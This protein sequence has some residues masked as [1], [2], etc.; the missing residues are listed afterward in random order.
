MSKHYDRDEAAE[1]LHSLCRSYGAFEVLVM[2]KN[3]VEVSASVDFHDNPNAVIHKDLITLEMAVA[4][5]MNNHVLRGGTAF[6]AADYSA[7]EQRV[8]VKPIKK[9]KADWKPVRYRG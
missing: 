9:R 3:T 5:G 6:T 2:L 4:D 8:H 7:L 1:I